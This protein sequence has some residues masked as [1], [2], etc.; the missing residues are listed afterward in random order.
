MGKVTGQSLGVWEPLPSTPY[1][2]RADKVRDLSISEA[3]VLYRDV[4][5]L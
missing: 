1:S 2:W 4:G 5:M 3:R